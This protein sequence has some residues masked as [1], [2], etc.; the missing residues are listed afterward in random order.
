M[1]HEHKWRRRAVLDACHFTSRVWVCDCG[2]IRRAY[3][4]RDGTLDAHAGQWLLEHG[5]GCKRCDE[6]LDGARPRHEDEIEER[7]IV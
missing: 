5:Q 1:R 6:L 2:S 4:E 7:A 3:D